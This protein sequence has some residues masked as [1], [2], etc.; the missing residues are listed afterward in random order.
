MGPLLVM[1]MRWSMRCAGTAKQ[2]GAV[3]FRGHP[4]PP[5]TVYS[6]FGVAS[7]PRCTRTVHGGTRDSL[8]GHSGIDGARIQ[9]HA[10]EWL[11]GRCIF[12]AAARVRPAIRRRRF[13]CQLP[14]WSGPVWSGTPRVPKRHVR[15]SETWYGRW[16]R[17]QDQGG[18]S[19]V[20]RSCRLH[21][22]ARANERDVHDDHSCTWHVK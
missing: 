11:D 17:G 1:S 8:V 15:T 5:C 14:I 16:R 2:V 4:T 6:S 22:Y 20:Q 19:A 3:Q 7:S 13:Y 9:I 10:P 18:P 21:I 12:V